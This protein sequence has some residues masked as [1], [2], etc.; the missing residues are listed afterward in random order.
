MQY[1]M[2]VYKGTGEHLITVRLP[3]AELQIDPQAMDSQH[4]SGSDSMWHQ[5]A[6]ASGQEGQP[7][8]S[9]NATASEAAVQV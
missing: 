3:A 1:V 6:L 7:F 5:Q 8:G 4:G 9:S 2:E